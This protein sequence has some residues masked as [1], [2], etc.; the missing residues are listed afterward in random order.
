MQSNDGEKRTRMSKA[1]WSGG[2]G[3]RAGNVAA[4]QPQLPIL[5][6]RPPGPAATTVP[7][8]PQAPMS[9]APKGHV[10][11]TAPEPQYP[12]HA[13]HFG[14][15]MQPPPVSYVPQVYPPP[16]PIQSFPLGPEWGPPLPRPKVSFA[17]MYA[18]QPS[19]GN[20]KNHWERA[21][22][23][24]VAIVDPNSKK[25]IRKEHI[26][27]FRKSSPDACEKCGS[28]A[29][30]A[31]KAAAI[32]KSLEAPDEASELQFLQE[33]VISAEDETIAKC[34]LADITCDSPTNIIRDIPTDKE[35]PT[36]QPDTGSEDFSTPLELT[37]SEGTTE[38]C[39]EEELGVASDNASVETGE[40]QQ[41]ECAI[42][43]ALK[44]GDDEEEEEEEEEEED[45]EEE[46]RILEVPAEISRKQYTLE[47]MHKLRH[48]KTYVKHIMDLKK[49]CPCVIRS[50]D[51]KRTQ[52]VNNLFPHYALKNNEN[53]IITTRCKR[54]QHGGGS[55]GRK[56]SPKRCA[57]LSAVKAQSDVIHV[58]LSMHEDVK[59]NVVENAWKPSVF[60]KKMPSDADERVETENLLK[61]FRGILNKITPKNFGALLMQVKE[62]KIDTKERLDAVIDLVFEK[63]VTEPKFKECYTKLSKQISMVYK[64]PPEL[65]AEQAMDFRRMLLNRVQHEFGTCVEMS[66]KSGADFDT[67]TDYDVMRKR[68][69]GSV[70][71]VGELF[72]FQLLAVKT[73]KSC[74][75]SLLKCGTLMSIELFC[76]LITTIGCQMERQEKSSARVL[77]QRVKDVVKTE[78]KKF[79]SRIKFM[80]M[81][82][83]DLQKT[84]IKEISANST[85]DTKK[86]M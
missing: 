44:M 23:H 30:E 28:A 17:A 65:M 60:A 56:L 46:R 2:N 66:K 36:E 74:A 63:A 13:P 9:M 11:T 24:A 3:R 49:K 25:D 12:P 81:D 16:M 34:D 4:W 57:K 78:K 67:E 75:Q 51:V 18:P 6:Y 33:S 59:L 39:V 37:S 20:N 72:N 45:A 70:Q 22:P 41:E 48:K 73:M 31:A 21:A 47:I 76:N 8:M 62:L 71:F 64:P 79:P 10:Y 55:A 80:V 84:W 53:V 1:E 52:I 14:M 38:E 32:A 54:D 43:I 19:S 42:A 29:E 61:L 35:T 5:R 15:P 40:S 27:S 50:I 58:S 83:D 86:P 7:L 85:K 69:I 77:I 68:A 82:L 26:E